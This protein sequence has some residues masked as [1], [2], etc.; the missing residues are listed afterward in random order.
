MPRNGCAP[1]CPSTGSSMPRFGLPRPRRWPVPNPRSPTFYR[2]NANPGTPNPNRSRGAAWP[3]ARGSEQWWGISVP[4]PRTWGEQPNERTARSARPGSELHHP[5]RKPSMERKTP[6]INLADLPLEPYGEGGHFAAMLGRAGAT[7]GT[8]QIG[9]TL[10]VLEPGKRAWPYHLHYAEEEL[11]VVLEGEG[12]LRY[13]DEEF[14]IRSG[15]MVLTPPRSGHRSPDHQH[16]GDEVALPRPQRKAK[17]GGLLLPGFRK[18]RRV[19]WRAEG[20]RIHRQGRERGRLLARRDDRAAPHL[21]S[22]ER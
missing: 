14:P 17:T 8:R 21:L 6:I 2:A 11:F 19:L 4:A 22:R 12:T 1:T 7:L 9:C 10:V 13:D 16:V 18:V 15:D 5:K 20:R 3:L